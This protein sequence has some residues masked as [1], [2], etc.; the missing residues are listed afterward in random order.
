MHIIF[1]LIFSSVE[2]FKYGTRA[3]I[4]RKNELSSSTKLSC[5]MRASPEE[6]DAVGIILRERMIIY[7]TYYNTPTT[8]AKYVCSHPCTHYIYIYIM[9]IPYTRVCVRSNRTIVRRRIY[10]IIPIRAGIVKLPQQCV[11]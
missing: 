1:L 9:Y 2:L 7:Y 10:T 11:V 4:P 8:V 3:T 6:D 5:T